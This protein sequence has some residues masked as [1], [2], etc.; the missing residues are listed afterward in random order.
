MEAFMAR[1]GKINLVVTS[2]PC[3]QNAHLFEIYGGADRNRTDGLIRA[4]DAL[5]Q[6]SYCPVDFTLVSYDYAWKLICFSLSVK[7]K[8]SPGHCKLQP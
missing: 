5:S 3:H 1:I 7:K 8:I 4:R 6:L 2:Q